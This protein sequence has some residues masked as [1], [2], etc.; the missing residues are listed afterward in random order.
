M[1]TSPSL[2]FPALQPGPSTTWG[3]PTVS[4]TGDIFSGLGD[5]TDGPYVATDPDISI[6]DN[7]TWVHGKHSIDLGF[8]YERQTFNELGNQFSRGNFVFQA[9]ATA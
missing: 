9:N 2:G 5:S 3:I 8:Q 1:T 6:N 4:F 7:I